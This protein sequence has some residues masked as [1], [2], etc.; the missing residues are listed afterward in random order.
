MTRGKRS[1]MLDLERELSEKIPGPLNHEDWVD[2]KKG[3]PLS[4]EVEAVHNKMKGHIH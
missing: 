3:D 4:A 1:D 2:K